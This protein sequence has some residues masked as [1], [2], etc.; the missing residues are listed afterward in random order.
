MDLAGHIAGAGLV[1]LSGGNPGYLV[2]TLRGTRVWGAVLANWDRGAVLAGCS[3]GAIALTSRADDVRAKRTVAGLGVVEELVVIPH[4]DHS[5]ECWPGAFGRRQAELQS[6]QALVGLDDETALIRHG[7]R[8]W[9]VRGRGA[10]W[11]VTECGALRA[12]PAGSELD[13]RQVSRV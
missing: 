12:L 13:L 2:E 8:Q 6:G 10:A 4:F 9:G 1:Y 7:W 5:E 11:L 3:A